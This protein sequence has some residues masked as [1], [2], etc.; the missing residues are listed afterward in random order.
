MAT[1]AEET[2]TGRDVT[3]TGKR[4]STKNPQA[5][6]DRVAA[7]Y[8]RFRNGRNRHNPAWVAILEKQ[9]EIRNA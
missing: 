8:K 6:I 3:R 1:R 9:K 5:K 4:Q 7:Y 2:A